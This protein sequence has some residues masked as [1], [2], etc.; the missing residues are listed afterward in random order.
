MVCARLL[1]SRQPGSRRQLKIELHYG[2]ALVADD[3]GEYDVTFSGLASVDGRQFEVSKTIV[4]RV[5]P[6]AVLVSYSLRGPQRLQTGQ[7]SQVLFGAKHF[8]GRSSGVD[9]SR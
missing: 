9:G 1:T 3:V 8:G 6:A 4:V 7:T 2:S 5:I